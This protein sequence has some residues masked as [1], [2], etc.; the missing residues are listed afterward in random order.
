MDNKYVP[1]IYLLY[2]NTGASGDSMKLTKD[3][4][5]PTFK[6]KEGIKGD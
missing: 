2:S 5:Y 3:I 1:Y 6:F 4:L